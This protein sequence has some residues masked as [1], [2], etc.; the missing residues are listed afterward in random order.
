MACCDEKNCLALWNSLWHRLKVILFQICSIVCNRA[1]LL[2]YNITLSTTEFLR[3][4]FDYV[5]WQSAL[6]VLAYFD[7]VLGRSLVYGV[8]SV[9]NPFYNIHILVFSLY[10]WSL[11]IICYLWLCEHHLKEKKTVNK[12]C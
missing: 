8:Y 3:K 4:D 9:S 12:I 11:F 6:N 7:Q 1:G 2:S 5:S 10:L